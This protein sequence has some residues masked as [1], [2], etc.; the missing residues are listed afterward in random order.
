MHGK[1]CRKFIAAGPFPS[2][3]LWLADPFATGRAL[4]GFGEPREEPPNTTSDETN[5]CN[6]Q[7]FLGAIRGRQANQKRNRSR[8]LGRNLTSQPPQLFPG[9]FANATSRR[10]L[11]K[12]T[13]AHGGVLLGMRGNQLLSNTANMAFHGYFPLLPIPLLFTL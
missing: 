13:V 9:P 7:R 5:S 6:R 1:S 3:A 2:P 10:S 8:C 4:R 12:K 11:E